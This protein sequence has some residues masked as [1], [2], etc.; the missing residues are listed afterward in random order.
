[1][2]ISEHKVEEVEPEKPKRG[3]GKKDDDEKKAANME[4]HQRLIEAKTE[5]EKKKALRKEQKDKQEMD[6]CTF[7]PSINEKSK[8]LDSRFKNGGAPAPEKPK[9]AKVAIF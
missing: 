9:D 3:S 4:Y 2:D 6:K 5:Y 1:M 8:N 7:K